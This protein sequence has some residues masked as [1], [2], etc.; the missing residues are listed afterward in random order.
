MFEVVNVEDLLDQSIGQCSGCV[1]KSVPF[2]TGIVHC[3][4][5]HIGSAARLRRITEAAIPLA[6]SR[7]LA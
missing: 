7:R 3:Q 6:A 5:G 1:G 4:R 2:A